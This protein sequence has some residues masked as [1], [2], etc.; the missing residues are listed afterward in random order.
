SGLLTGAAPPR[1][2]G[3]ELQ[4]ELLLYGLSLTLHTLLA[5]T[6]PPVAL[7]GHSLGFLPALVGA[8]AFGVED[9]CRLV[10]V[11]HRVLAEHPPPPGGMLHLDTGADT[12]AALAASVPGTTV[13]CVNSPVRT[14]LSGPAGALAHAEERARGLGLSPLR[15]PVRHAYHGPGLEPALTEM[16]RRCHGIRR[17]PLTTPLYSATTGTFHGDD[18][19]LLDA[20]FA[21]VA[22]P[23]HFRDALR[24]LAARGA[25]AFVECGPTPMLTRMAEETVPRLPALPALHPGRPPAETLRSARDLAA[26]VKEVSGTA[27]RAAGTR[28]EPPPGGLPA[29]G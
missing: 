23:V 17:R 15:L 19:D 21:S 9:G 8:G 2:P 11:R 4:H 24:A 3:R 25:T 14:V 20:L 29:P 10:L 18:E 13:A 6:A 7:L 22:R 28:Q 1:S 27:P 26:P 5:A 16:R 12:A